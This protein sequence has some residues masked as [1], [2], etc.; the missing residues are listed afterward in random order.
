MKSES[1]VSVVVIPTHLNDI[2][3][4]LSTLSTRLDE[5]YSDYEIVVIAPG[6]TAQM[7]KQKIAF[8]RIFLVCESSS[9]QLRCF[10][11]LLL[12]QD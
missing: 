4:P 3:S 2:Y 6:L 12:P 11:M 9:F 8:S 10:M 1:F 7:P 5:Q